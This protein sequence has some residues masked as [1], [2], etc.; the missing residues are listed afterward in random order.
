VS[1]I[2]ATTKPTFKMANAGGDIVRETFGTSQSIS[3]T[4]YMQFGVRYNFN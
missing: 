2:S 1:A 3:S 4:Y